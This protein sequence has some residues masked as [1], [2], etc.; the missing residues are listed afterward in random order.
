MSFLSPKYRQG[1]SLTT[2]AEIANVSTH[3]TLNKFQSRPIRSEESRRLCKKETKRI[4]NMVTNSRVRI[5]TFTP[6]ATLDIAENVKTSNPKCVGTVSFKPQFA[7]AGKLHMQKV[8]ANPVICTNI[9]NQRG[10][11]Y[12]R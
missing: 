4:A 11:R 2:C 3:N 9:E 5:C 10:G 8:N 7:V 1:W 6:N 12:E